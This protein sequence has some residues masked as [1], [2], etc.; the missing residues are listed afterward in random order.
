[1][2]G[3]RKAMA[4]WFYLDRMSLTSGPCLPIQMNTQTAG[5]TRLIAGRGA[6]LISLQQTQAVSPTTRL[7]ARRSTRFSRGRSGQDGSG[8]RQSGFWSMTLQGCLR[9]SAG[10]F[11]CQRT[12]WRQPQTPP[13]KVAQHHAKRPVLL[14]H[15]HK[16]M[17]WLLV[18]ISCNRTPSGHVYPK[19]ARPAARVLS[20]L[21]AG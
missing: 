19:G 10:A 15:F 13:V 8:H 1:M 9:R 4:P 11:G 12:A 21:N 2:T 3:C 18:K 5:P 14:M 6:P 17:M 7:V 20:A 16:D